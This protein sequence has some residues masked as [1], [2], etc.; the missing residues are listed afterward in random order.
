MDAAGWK[1]EG[2]KHFAA[3]A[4]PEAIEAF[5]QAIA[6]DEANHVL[7]S[8]R[9]AAHGS[10]GDWATAKEDASKCVSL[11]PA[12][13]KGYI[14]LGAAH[15][16]LQDLEGAVAQ[17]EKGLEIEPENATLKSSLATVQQDIAAAAAPAENPFGKMF[18]AQT[19]A[20]VAANP[21]LA[22]F[23]A[24]PDYVQKVN[25]IIAN[26]AMAQGLMQDQRIMQTMLMLSGINMDAMGGMGDEDD[27]PAPMAAKPA[28]A[29]AKAAPKAAAK[30]GVSPAMA[31]KELGN[32]FYLKKEFPEAL[33]KYQAA[34]ALEPENTTFLL[35]MT[36]VYFEQADYAKCLEEC[37]KALDHSMDHNGGFTLNGKLITRKASCLQKQ[38]K[39]G[40]AI[41]MFKKALL[42]NRNADTLKKLN[43]CEEEKKKNDIA[44]Y[45]SPEL[46]L[47]A[48]EEGNAFFKADK[49]PEAVKC[50]DEAIKRAPTNHVLYCNRA[51]A[52]LKLGAHESVISDCDKSIELD[53]T[54][55]KAYA[56]K[57]HAYFWTK[58]YNKAL[59]AYAEGR[60]IDENNVECIEGHQKTMGKVQ[61]MQGGEGDNEAAQRAMA[62]PEIQQI[63]GDTYM[64]MVLSE[65][66]KDPKK[67]N[68]YMKDK[69]IAAKINKLMVA[70]VLRTGPAP[71]GGAKPGRR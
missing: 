55:V 12:W 5:T 18:N 71:A 52:L 64:Q 63:M 67:I 45:L 26:P 13:P 47:K 28:P 42:E 44:A 37:D 7:Y 15:H 39:H 60:A 66:Q 27:A 62:D 48:K 56:R 1:A 53:A 51:A 20:K 31:E 3:K 40:E 61:E 46:S 14:R 54:F 4:F 2:N 36:A 65:M 9:S 33:A 35:N 34:A 19:L 11:N 22:P 70:G 6:Q 29:A 58:Q 25:M 57:G 16:G 30:P 69:D 49:F 68:D 24:Q 41:P 10:L 59:A 38:G 23:L 43:M 8:N 32:A 50:Y 21:K 17:Y